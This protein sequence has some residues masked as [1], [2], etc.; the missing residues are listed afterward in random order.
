MENESLVLEAG[1][2]LF[3]PNAFHLLHEPAS[4]QQLQ[5]WTRD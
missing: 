4:T 2:L 3:F 5:R 1:R